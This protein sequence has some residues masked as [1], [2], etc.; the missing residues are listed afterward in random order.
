MGGGRGPNPDGFVPSEGSTSEVVNGHEVSSGSFIRTKV[1]NLAA[2]NGS[3]Y[4]C[5]TR[6][7]LFYAPHSGLGPYA[8]SPLIIRCAGGVFTV[9]RRGRTR[10]WSAPDGVTSPRST[11]PSAP[12]RAT[13]AS[14]RRR[15]SRTPWSA[16]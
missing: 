8:A 14:A 9:Q 4:L 2:L 15:V 5:T 12:S 13:A 16:P 3:P 6:R 1:G 10:G 7:P 11:R